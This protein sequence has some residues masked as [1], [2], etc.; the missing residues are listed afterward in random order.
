MDNCGTILENFHNVIVTGD[1]D[2]L[3]VISDNC[4]T[5]LKNTGNGREF[6]TARL[7]LQIRNES[8]ANFD[9]LDCVGN[10]NLSV[11]KN[12]DDRVVA[13]SLENVVVAEYTFDL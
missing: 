11:V 1:V 10:F 8:L 3:D 9:V 6:F 7:F 2:I 13:T 12:V 4:C 5:V